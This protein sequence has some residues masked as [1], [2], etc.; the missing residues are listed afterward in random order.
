M[1]KLF[2]FI[3]LFAITLSSQT[4]VKTKVIYTDTVRANVDTVRFPSYTKFNRPLWFDAEVRYL[5][6]ILFRSSQDTLATKA[7]ARSNGGTGGGFLLTTDT[8][9]FRNVSNSYYLKNNDSTLNRIFSDLKY[10]PKQSTLDSLLTH[11]NYFS[12]IKDTVN[13][14]NTRLLALVDSVKNHRTFINANRDSIIK[15]TKYHVQTVSSITS[16][17]DSL[18]NK[19]NR[20]DTTNILLSKSYATNMLWSKSNLDTANRWAPAGTKSW[21]STY[22]YKK[23]MIDALLGYKFNKFDTTY[24]HALKFS[25]INDSITSHNNRIL[26]LVS[27][28]GSADSAVYDMKSA[29]TVISGSKIFTGTNNFNALQKFNNQIELFGTEG[30]FSN[31]IKSQNSSNKMGFKFVQDYTSSDGTGYFGFKNHVFGLYDSS[32]VTP[33]AVYDIGQTI[34][35]VLGEIS[36]GVVGTDQLSSKDGIASSIS[37]N[38]SFAMAGNTIADAGDI[39]PATTSVSDLGKYNYKFDSLHVNSISLTNSLDTSKVN[40]VATITT[41]G[42]L[43]ATRYNSKDFQLKLPQAIASTSSPTFAGLTLTNNLILNG[44]DIRILAG[45]STGRGIFSNDNVS[46]YVVAYGSTHATVPSQLDLVGSGGISMNG[47]TTLN[48][49]LTTTGTTTSPDFFANKTGNAGYFLQYSGGNRYVT[50][51]D[52]SDSGY[53]VYDYVR[54]K[55]AFTSIHGNF[56]TDGGS[57]NGNTTLA[58]TSSPTF[59]GLTLNGSL[60]SGA[61]TSSGNLTIN[62]TGTNTFVADVNITGRPYAE[63]YV[64]DTTNNNTLTTSSVYYTFK[65]FNQTGL[66]NNATWTDSTIIISLAGVYK[67]S[68]TFVLAVNNP[69]EE[70][71]IAVFVNNNE[72]MKS[73]T[74]SQMAGSG[75]HYDFAF[76]CLSSLSANDIIKVKVKNV[77]SSGKVVTMHNANW[78]IEKIN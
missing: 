9:G 15:A 5:S 41:D 60:Y 45:T 72:L 25:N 23:A 8:I 10:A 32:G 42:T 16:L 68:G 36:A 30:I 78:G 48:G 19:Y 69:N 1:K 20:S 13:I 77:T 65:K 28:V 73:E 59:A 46:A 39:Y 11:R 54:S 71:H 52:N 6:S 2:F 55:H 51:Y 43:T 49:T 17:T 70:V 24:L 76:R 27:G 3:L 4:I 31:Y 53:K 40:S 35:S 7:Y 66:I 44:S 34:F 61:I 47:A 67:I 56:S 57:I 18:L 75:D 58:S 50:Y 38:K 63:L 74:E 64:A 62:G 14:H 26:A 22:A 21:D 12:V 29:N 37:V 33:Y